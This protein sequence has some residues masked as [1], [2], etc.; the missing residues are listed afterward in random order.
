MNYSNKM[1]ESQE[2]VNLKGQVTEKYVKCN[3][4]YIKF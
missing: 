1:N 4:I 3:F 2:Y